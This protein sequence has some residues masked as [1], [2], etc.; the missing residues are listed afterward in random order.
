MWTE[1][2]VNKKLNEEYDLKVSQKIESLNSFVDKLRKNLK[3]P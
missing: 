3:D 2:E 1:L